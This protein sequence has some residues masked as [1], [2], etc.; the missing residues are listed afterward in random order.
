MKNSKSLLFALCVISITTG[1]LTPYQ[2]PPP[3]PIA[4]YVE[5]EYAALAKSGT[6]S[7]SGQAFARTRGGDVRYAAGSDVILT[8]ATAHGIDWA[9]RTE[10]EGIGLSIGVHPNSLR[11]PQL[12][13]RAKA[14]TKTTV[15]DA[16]GRF[17]F[18]GLSA[19][20]YVIVSS[21]IWEVPRS[22]G[23]SSYMGVTGGYLVGTVTVKDGEK[24]SVIV[25]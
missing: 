4:A 9:R 1:C 2:E 22:T 25:K 7:V 15:A 17:T 24:G 16:N 20:S 3:K 12:D 8:P 11:L 21:V 6:A 14:F 5:A 10:E 13:D 18:D 19:G 23:R